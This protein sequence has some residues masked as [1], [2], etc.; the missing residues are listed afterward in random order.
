MLEYVCTFIGVFTDVFILHVF[1]NQYRIKSS[2]WGES[3]LF[4]G[5]GLLSIL[6]NIFELNFFVKLAISISLCVIIIIL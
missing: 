3:C 4:G 5:F 2:R 1:L 6:L